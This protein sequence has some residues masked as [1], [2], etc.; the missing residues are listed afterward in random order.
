M[1]IWCKPVHRLELQTNFKKICAAHL[2]VR[3]DIGTKFPY[4]LFLPWLSNFWVWA[5][6]IDDDDKQQSE[7]KAHGDWSVSRLRA[8]KMYR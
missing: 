3:L 2:P 1:T 7:T 6:N 8:K 5:F 4:F